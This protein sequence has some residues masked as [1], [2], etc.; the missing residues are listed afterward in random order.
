M[1]LSG[2]K[3]IKNFEVG[4]SNF[5]YGSTDISLTFDDKTITFD[6][7]YVGEEPLCSL[8]VSVYELD[9]YPVNVGEET[10][11]LEWQSEPGYFKIYMNRIISTGLLYL[12]IETD[13][14]DGTYL[15]EVRKYSYV[16]PYQMYKDSIIK[17]ALRALKTYGLTGFNENWIDGPDTF[18][19]GALLNIMGYEAKRVENEFYSD[20][21][22]EY[23]FLI[24]RMKEV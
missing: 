3:E 19:L 9:R 22:N 23:E 8:I 16:V 4:I 12:D 2:Y 5:C 11:D 14:I 7:T 18:P 21:A 20:I 10:W 24:Q 1:E 15:D 13:R 6:A 17:C